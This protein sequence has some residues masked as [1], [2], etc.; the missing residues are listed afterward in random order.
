[1]GRPSKKE[2][3][4]EEILDAFYRCVARYGLDGSTLERVAEESGLKRSL[5][6][7]FVGNREA[8]ESLLVDR[9]LEQSLQQWRGF[10]DALPARNRC[11][12][13]LQ[14]LFSDQYSDAEY[15]LVIESLIFSSAR[16]KVLRLRMQEWMQR[17]TDDIT[18]ILKSDHPKSADQDLEAVSFGLISLYFN[19]DSLAPLGLNQRY[20]QPACIAA[21]HLLNS[22]TTN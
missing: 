10:I 4:T 11:D 20:R 15:I 3:R 12:H 21:Q 8:L 18:L 14:G 5:V 13:L 17:F 1:M 9:V 2:E 7:H 22:L 16:D 6:R 19:L